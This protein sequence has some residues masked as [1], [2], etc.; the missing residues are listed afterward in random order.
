MGYEYDWSVV[1]EP[2][3]WLDAIYI[4]L[5]YGLGTT[6]VGLVLGLVL[7]LILISSF[8]PGRWLVQLFI[9]VFRC[10]PALIQIVWFYYAFPIVLGVNLPAWLAAGCG[11]TF[12]MA[13]FS[14]EI[15]RGGVQSI[16]ARQWSACRSLCMSYWQTMR[17]VILPQTFRRMTPAIVNQAIIQFKNTSLL[18]VVAVHDLMY[19]ANT[20]TAQTYRPLEVLTFAAVIYMLMIW[21]L[22]SLTNRYERRTNERLL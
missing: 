17:Y 3:L 18:S 14:A 7:G 2:S 19:T 5:V 22:A 9:G 10:T 11:L 8:A 13:A 1:L 16:D 12:Y 4:T 6:F 20:L 15:F 21:P